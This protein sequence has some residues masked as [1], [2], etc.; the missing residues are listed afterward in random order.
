MLKELLT[1][2]RQKFIAEKSWLDQAVF[3]LVYF[4]RMMRFCRMFNFSEEW[5]IVVGALRGINRAPSLT[6]FFFSFT[7]FL[8]RVFLL[9]FSFSFLFFFFYPP[10]ESY[11]KINI[12]FRF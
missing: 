12:C 1:G 3:P 10:F 7:F 8:F 2:I 6:A 9:Y 11:C 4:T 5:N